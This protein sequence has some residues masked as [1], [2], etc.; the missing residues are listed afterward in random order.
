MPKRRRKKSPPL[1]SLI[2]K[3]LFPNRRL[4]ESWL[5]LLPKRLIKPARWI[6]SIIVVSLIL[7]WS[8]LESLP[9]PLPTS[10]QPPLLYSYQCH[11]NLR[12]LYVKAIQE[13]KQSVWLS[14]YSLSDPRI[15]RALKEKAEEG[16]NVTVFH[17]P[18]TPQKGFL[19]LGDKVHTIAKMGSGLMHQKILIIDDTTIWIG[20]ANF[21]VDSLRFQDNLVIGLQSQALAEHIKQKNARHSQMI[22]A[23]GQMVEYW[24]FPSQ[25]RDGL[26]RLLQLIDSAQKTVRVAMFTFTHPDLTAALIRAH[27]RKVS[28]EVV[29]DQKQAS[30][31]CTQ[32]L[33]ALQRS[34]IAVRLSGTQSLFHHK[35][36]WIDEKIL[37][38]GSANWTKSAFSRN[39]DCLLIL[40]PLSIGQNKKMKE[41]WH[42]IRARSFEEKHSSFQ[43]P[44]KAQVEVSLAA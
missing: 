18:E 44:L 6:F 29:M 34:G 39:D 4:T 32:T 16:I 7:L 25:G 26:E 21:T 19:Q 37:I 15:I 11:D 42:A 30:G 20:S 28:V 9:P 41:L 31:V 40:Y 24:E 1:N 27:R 43:A 5:N 17:D 8:T 23:G 10:E 35:C 22:S 38:N 3:H 12:D 33:I 13:S 14:I 2:K 36:A